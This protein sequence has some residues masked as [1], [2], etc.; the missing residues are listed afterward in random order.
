MTHDTR[1]DCAPDLQQLLG[2]AIGREASDVH[3]FAG[4]APLVRIHGVLQPLREATLSDEQVVEMIRSVCPAELEERLEAARQADF[5][6]ALD[7][8]GRRHRFRV[9]VFFSQ[10]R[11][12]AALRLIPSEIPSVEW[13]G[14]PEELVERVV[15]LRNG[16]VLVTGITGFG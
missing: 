15:A 7:H 13:A 11:R 10:G 3:L 4:Y 2:E 16:L 14:L 5:S 6:I 8:G 12:G 9:N 1:N